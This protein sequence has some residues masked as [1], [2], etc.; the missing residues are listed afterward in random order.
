ME[1]VFIVD[2]FRA[3]K[4]HRCSRGPSMQKL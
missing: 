1:P 4:R 3:L 2:A